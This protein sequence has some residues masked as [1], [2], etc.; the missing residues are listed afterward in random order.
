MTHKIRS[1]LGEEELILACF[2]SSFIQLKEPNL[3]SD[4]FRVDKYKFQNDNIQLQ[5]T[6]NYQSTNA[7]T[8]QV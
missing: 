7:N 6:K 1:S 3:T 4:E 2:Q 8:N 5:K